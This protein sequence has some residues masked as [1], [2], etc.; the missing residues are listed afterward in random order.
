MANAW[1]N[2]ITAGSPIPLQYP[3]YKEESDVLIVLDEPDYELNSH[4]R[5]SYCDMWDRLGYFY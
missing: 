2:C 1:A 5:T 4:V 3:L